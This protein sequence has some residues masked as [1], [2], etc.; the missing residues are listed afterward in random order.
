MLLD[1]KKINK[2]FDIN[3][4]TIQI[5]NSLSFS[6]KHNEIISIYGASGSGKSTLLNI[7]SGL[8]SYDS[9]SILFNGELMNS[10]FD[11]IKFR[12]KD[13]GIVFQE[14]HLL[15]EFTA[16]ENIMLPSIISGKS[17]NRAYHIAYNLLDRFGLLSIKDSYS[18]TLSGGE[19]QRVSILRAVINN[20]KLIL[21]DEPTGSIDE[22]N[23]EQIFSLFKEIVKEYDTSILIATH[24][25]N[26]SK[27]SNK[28]LNLSKGKIN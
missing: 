10:R 15:M 28:I 27:I 13:L 11:F 18:N 2:S 1:V 16:I 5:L 20:P 25:N 22:S 24:D 23:K 4:K 12:K 6:V 9:G 8:M 3:K 21:A 19:K 7:I 26:V 17:R 14:D